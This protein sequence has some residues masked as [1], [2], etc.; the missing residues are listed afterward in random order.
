MGVIYSCRTSS[1]LS[2]TLRQKA[3][4][5]VDVMTVIVL[6]P[7]LILREHKVQLPGGGAGGA[8]HRV[9]P[10]VHRQRQDC[11]RRVP[12]QCL[13]CLSGGCRVIIMCVYGPGGRSQA[14]FLDQPDPLR[15]QGAFL[16]AP[17]YSF[18]RFGT[19]FNI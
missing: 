16:D 13:R 15:T 5:M 10:H 7:V 6:K 2:T 1:Y 8:G 19:L 14:K 9:H 17:E 12:A 4:Q 3:L 11:G 18:N